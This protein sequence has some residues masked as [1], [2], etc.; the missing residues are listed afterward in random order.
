MLVDEPEKVRNIKIS[1]ARRAKRVD[2][3]KLKNSIWTELCVSN[4]SQSENQSPN[5]PPERI[6]E[7]DVSDKTFTQVL[8]SLPNSVPQSQMTDLSVPLCFICLLDLANKKGLQIDQ[9]DNDLSIKKYK[10]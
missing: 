1:Y 7:D 5:I 2:I 3:E 9:L 8:Q 4:N 10:K 6:I